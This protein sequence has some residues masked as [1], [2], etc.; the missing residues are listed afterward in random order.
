[1]KVGNIIKPVAAGVV[2]LVL[3]GGYKYR[4]SGKTEGA[5]AFVKM[6]NEDD[7]KKGKNDYSYE[8]TKSLK[9]NKD[10]IQSKIII[11]DENYRLFSDLAIGIAKK[12]TNFGLDLRYP[13]KKF[14]SDL[15][16]NKKNN[17]EGLSSGL[18]NFKVEDVGEY[19]K[20]RLRDLDALDVFDPSKSAIATIVHLNFLNDQYYVYL[21]NIAPYQDEPLTKEEYILARWKNLRL[22][23]TSKNPDIKK[24]A[25]FNMNAIIKDRTAA[26]P[27]YYVWKILESAGYFYNEE[28]GKVEKKDK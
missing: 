8:F 4:Q 16:F 20:D 9:D 6:L 3:I 1:M 10:K 22:D 19:E 18:T 7:I 26:K 2:G 25:T 21:Q 23:T 27:K 24:K 28:S 17:Q 15:G 11:S 12:E 5:D 13:I 14:L